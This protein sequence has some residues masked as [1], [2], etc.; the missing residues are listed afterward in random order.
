M[1]L[2]GVWECVET[3]PDGTTLVRHTG[4]YAVCAQVAADMVACGFRAD[5]RR[6]REGAS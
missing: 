6:H 2:K 1:R 3:F 4:S 5:V